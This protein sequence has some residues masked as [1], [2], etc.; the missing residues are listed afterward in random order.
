MDKDEARFIL[1]SFRPDGADA[2]DADFTEALK[3]AAG[4]RELGE[5]LADERALDSAFSQALGSIAAPASLRERILAGATA[6][7]GG[8]PQAECDLDARMI[9]AMAAVQPP[10]EMRCKLLAA[11]MQSRAEEAQPQWWRK[12]AWPLAAAAGIALA[13]IFTGGSGVPAAP[14][15][16]NLP[17]V[18][19]PAGIF[20]ITVVEPGT[21]PVQMVQ[22]SF[23]QIFESPLYEVG[24]EFPET[25]EQIIQILEKKK[26]PC[27]KCLPP[28]LVG[29]EGLG[30][31]ELVIGGKRGSLVC[32]DDPENGRVHLAIFKREDVCGE[33]PTREK[34]QMTQCGPWAVARWVDENHVFVLI[35]SKPMDKLAGL[36]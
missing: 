20:P 21:I 12:A 36:F 32:L 14:V 13:F 1:Q 19:Q 24:G 16:D 23:I 7:L 9:G 25:H 22:D 28:G 29:V 4:D 8:R 26:L 10:A 27:P 34:P 31:R 11:M 15:A 2:G 6:G 17:A 18:T 33:L 30:C 35:G 3:L 5:W